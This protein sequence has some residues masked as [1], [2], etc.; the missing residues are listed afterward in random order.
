MNTLLILYRWLERTIFNTL[1]RKILGNLLPLGLLTVIPAIVWWNLRGRLEHIFTGGGSPEEMITAIRTILAGGEIWFWLLAGCGVTGMI[2]NYLFLR[3]LMIMPVTRMIAF[4]NAHDSKEVDLS[5]PLPVSTVDEFQD[6]AE[7]YN[8][9]LE[10]LREMISAVR[11]TGVNIAINSCRAAKA[12]GETTTSAQIQ[13][14]MA[15]EIYNFSEQSTQAIDQV[16]QNCQIVSA[17][18]SN[19]LEMARSSMGELHEATSK[20]DQSL[21]QL[22]E[23]EGTVTTLNSNSTKISKI[24]KLIQNIAFQTNLLALN[25]AVEAAR[26]GQHGKGFAVVAEEVRNLATR[27]NQ[28]TNDVSE[29]ISAMTGLVEKTASQAGNIFGNIGATKTVIDSAHHHFTQIVE[30]LDNNSGQ[31]MRIA[32]ATEQLAASNVEIHSKVGEI[33]HTSLAVSEQMGNA[34]NATVE[35]GTITEKMQEMVSHFTIGRGNFERILA[36][37]HNHRDEVQS[38]IEGIASRGINVLDRNHQPIPGTNPVKYSTAFD[39]EFDQ[40]F[41]RLFDQYRSAVK[42][43]IYTIAMDSSGYVPTHHSNVSQPLTGN[44]E[45]DLLNSRHKRIFMANSVEIRRA[46][47]TQPFLLQTYSRDTGEILSDLSL[48]IYIKGQHWGAFITGFDPQL[49]L[50]G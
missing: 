7:S 24:V 50:E 36:T 4:F 22:R 8:R 13:E 35:L 32:A 14:S 21:T 5:D 41:Q 17:T 49:L 3:Y 27:V 15:G 16:A 28:A 48:P 19:N 39:R 37:L 9:F 12:I 23:F 40:A 44:Y 47:N 18:T 10:N 46:E 11:A 2:I 20:I 33:R 45:Q 43:F 26:A 42:G 31:L 29:S 25:A 30:D 1:N 38:I 6:L 34:G